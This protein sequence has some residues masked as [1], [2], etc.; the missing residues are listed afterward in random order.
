VFARYSPKSAD[1]SDA[2]EMLDQVKE[3]KEWLK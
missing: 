3:L 1:I 2:R